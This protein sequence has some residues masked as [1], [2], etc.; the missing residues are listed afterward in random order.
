MATQ[1][2][3][4]VKPSGGDYTTLN[5]C[6]AANQ[7]D[8]VAADKY[9]DVE[10]DGTWASADTTAVAGLTNYTTDATRYINIYTTAAARHL[11][12]RGGGIRFSF[13]VA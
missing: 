2:K 11:G 8:L 10:I 6:L 12:M 7:Q 9:F 13:T 4:T 3:K 1:L 5:A